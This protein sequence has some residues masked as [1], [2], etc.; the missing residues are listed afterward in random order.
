MVERLEQ[1]VYKPMLVL[2]ITIIIL[3]I[4]GQA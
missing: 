2:I 4:E 3:L 1:F